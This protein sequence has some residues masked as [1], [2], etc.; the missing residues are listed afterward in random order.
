MMM[1]AFLLGVIFTASL[2][3]ALIFLK[4]WRDTRDSFFLAFAAF[5]TIESANRITLVFL[6]RPNEGALHPE[7][8]R[9]AV[10]PGGHS[11]Q[12]LQT[13]VIPAAAHS[14]LGR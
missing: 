8:V 11:P 12:E 13:S 2:V 7:A 10:D 4:F 9:T 1:N 14:R 6:D 3:A 5:F